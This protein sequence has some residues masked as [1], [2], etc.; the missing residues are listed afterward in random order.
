V[1][2]FSGLLSG[3]KERLTILN[4]DDAIVRRP[5]EFGQVAALGFDGPDD[6]FAL[7]RAM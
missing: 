5:V 6:Q 1:E 3:T 7:L 4:A 2:S